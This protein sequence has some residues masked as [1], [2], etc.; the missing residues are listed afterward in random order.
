[1]ARIGVRSLLMITMM[2]MEELHGTN[3]IHWI[4]AM[5]TDVMGPA[6]IAL[7]DRLDDHWCTTPEGLFTILRVMTRSYW[8]SSEKADTRMRLLNDEGV[9]EVGGGD[10]GGGGRG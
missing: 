2:M 4:I 8:C 1:M 6:T 3:L 10:G 5:S 7:W 9:D